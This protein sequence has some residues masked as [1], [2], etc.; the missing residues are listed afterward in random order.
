MSRVLALDFD[1]VIADALDECALV[2]LLGA[3]P[4]DR[5]VPGR[6][7]IASMRAR[8]GGAYLARFRHVRDYSRLLDHFVVA[9]LPEGGRVADQAAFDA[10]FRT[11]PAGHVRD[12]TARATAAREWF[13]TREPAFWL[14]LHTL[15]PG[16]PELLRRH[17]GSVVVV[18]AKDEGSV[19]AILRRHGLEDT[20]REVFGECARKADAVR[21]VAGRW[22]VSPADVTFVDD[23]LANVR[24]VAA[25]GAD[26]RWARWGYQ[27]PEHRAEAER[28]AVPSL[29][30]ADL[31]ALAPVA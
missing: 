19:R 7:Q 5:S 3:R 16:V 27:T 9:H 18:T 23:N 13:R 2:T 8:E 17:R 6:E 12:F 20:V 29:E 31:A 10:L 26:A 1:G 28:Y 11:L 4:L 25:T 22:G 14:D 21:D 24:A 15:Y 30:L